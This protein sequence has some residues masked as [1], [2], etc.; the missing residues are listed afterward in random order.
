MDLG[1]RAALSVPVIALFVAIMSALIAVVTEPDN[2]LIEGWSLAWVTFDYTLIVA[3]SV[4]VALSFPTVIFGDRLP[5]PR[6]AWLVGLGIVLSATLGLLMLVF[7]GNSAFDIV[8]LFGALGAVSA[9][10]WW[11]LVERYREVEFTYD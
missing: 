11:L 5:H 10:L 6:W 8:M 3:I 9:G 2:A 1:G 4:G 7:A